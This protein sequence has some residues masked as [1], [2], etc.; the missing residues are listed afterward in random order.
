[1]MVSGNIDSSVIKIPQTTI[2]VKKDFTGDRKEVKFNA[3]MEKPVL[4][5][6]KIDIYSLY[7]N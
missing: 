7:S 6:V 2:T 5:H 4:K 1:M 3:S